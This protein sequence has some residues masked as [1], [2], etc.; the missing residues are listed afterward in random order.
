MRPDKANAALESVP[1]PYKWGERDCMRTAD[2]L[3]AAA[4]GD[5]PLLG[6]AYGEYAK[7]DH[8]AAVA[9]AQREHGSVRALYCLI[10]RGLPTRLTELAGT[11]AGEPGDI[12]IAEGNLLILG[13]W[14]DTGKH[15]EMLSFVDGAGR[16]L[17]W[18]HSGLAQFRGD[19]RLREAFRPLAGAPD[20]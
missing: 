9:R 5:R 12:I 19:Y 18:A 7:L 17:L 4:G 8:A 14:H 3:L 10:F 15:G 6:T 2:A 1:G 11:D 13:S 16:R 20:A